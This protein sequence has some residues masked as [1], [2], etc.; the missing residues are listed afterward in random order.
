MMFLIMS[1][2]ELSSPPGVSRRMIAIVA[3]LSAASLSALSI[4][5]CV[6]GS[7]VAFSSIE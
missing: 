6:A 2:I 3:R 1:R 7:I 5:F 4:H